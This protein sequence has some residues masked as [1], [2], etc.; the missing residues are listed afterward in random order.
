M[1]IQVGNKAYFT[2]PT[3]NRPRLSFSKNGV[4]EYLELTNDYNL[5]NPGN[6]FFVIINAVKH[7]IKEIF[8]KVG[9]MLASTV[10]YANG[11]SGGGW[12]PWT[13]FITT[14]QGFGFINS[15]YIK[16]TCTCGYGNFDYMG[17]EVIVANAKNTGKQI[18]KAYTWGSGSNWTGTYT[19][20]IY[21]SQA[22]L[23]ILGGKDTEIVVNQRA[24]I[25]RGSSG[26]QVIS[27]VEIFTT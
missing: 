27:K 3:A 6:K 23:D 15:L 24:Y 11:A 20:N 9:Y 25:N 19:I 16:L 17:A 4:T 10:T 2:R 5:T 13:G 12:S 18:F 1:K 7:W 26:A 8:V 14:I 22:E 21:L